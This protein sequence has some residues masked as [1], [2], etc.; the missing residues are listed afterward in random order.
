MLTSSRPDCQLLA[1]VDVT[2]LSPLTR[3]IES[4]LSLYTITSGH[5]VKGIGDVLAHEVDGLLDDLR[6][7]ICAIAG[8]DIRVS[9]V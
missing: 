5:T 4:F 6:V 2:L 1:E 9:V 3:L 7:S 8:S